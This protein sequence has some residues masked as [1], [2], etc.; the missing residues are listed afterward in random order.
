M[1]E[2]SNLTKHYNETVALIGASF[3]VNKGEIFAYLGPNGAGKTTTVNILVTLLKPTSGK[4]TVAGHDVSNKGKNVRRL[5]GYLPEDSGLYPNLTV[6]ENLDFT[7][8]LY[9]MNKQDKKWRISEL[10]ERLDLQE[11]RNAKASTL[12]KGMRQKVGLARVLMND[13]E[14]LFLDEPT[15]GLDPGMTREVL[16]L[17]H[18]QKKEGRTVFMTTHLLARA[19]QI[20]DSVALINKGKVIK[21]GNIAAIKA[22][23][24]STTLE[25]VYFEVMGGY[26]G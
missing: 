22:E 14:V 3:R 16:K 1:I 12:S 7:G 9:R 10:L 6:Q 2:V 24:K 26:N 11:K 8:S 15:S 4:A 20:C 25:D 23:L 17:I 13:P 18:G 5:I 19:E 21:S